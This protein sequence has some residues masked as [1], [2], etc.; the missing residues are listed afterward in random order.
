MQVAV[1]GLMVSPGI[2]DTRRA[3]HSLRLTAGADFRKRRADIRDTR[4]VLRHADI[5]ATQVYTQMAGMSCGGSRL[6][7]FWATVN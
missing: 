4:D 3:V 6:G 7:D 1:R 2:K 5:G